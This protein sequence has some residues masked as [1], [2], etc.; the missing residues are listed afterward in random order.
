MALVVGE[1]WGVGSCARWVVGSFAAKSGNY[2]LDAS[3]LTQASAGVGSFIRGVKKERIDGF[4]AVIVPWF[5]VGGRPYV[6]G[7]EFGPAM[8]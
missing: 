8:S 2:L 3:G 4:V 7:D 5:G 6:V 1:W